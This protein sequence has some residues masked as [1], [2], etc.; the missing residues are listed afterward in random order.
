MGKARPCLRL[1]PKVLPQSL[2]MLHQWIARKVDA[3]DSHM[4]TRDGDGDCVTFYSGM[5]FCH[6]IHVVMQAYIQGTP[7]GTGSTSHHS[8]Q[9]HC[10]A[11][12]A[13]FLGDRRCISTAVTV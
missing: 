12:R 9:M 10:A 11:R 2:K 8:E 6:G 4:T 3:Q 1:C 5:K 13:S 7:G